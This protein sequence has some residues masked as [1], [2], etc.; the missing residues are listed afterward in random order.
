MSYKIVYKNDGTVIG[1]GFPDEDSA[2]RELIRRGVKPGQTANFSVIP[3]KERT[4]YEERK[5]RFVNAPNKSFVR[6]NPG[7]DGH[8]AFGHRVDVDGV[9]L[10]ESVPAVF[11]YCF[12]VTDSDDLADVAFISFAVGNETVELFSGHWKSPLGPNWTSGKSLSELKIVF[13]H[14]FEVVFSF[15]F[16]KTLTVS[17]E[18]NILLIC[19]VCS[20]SAFRLL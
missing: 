9:L 6:R 15:N 4:S 17:I 14:Y 2:Y 13:K 1:R 11:I 3:D 12:P 5:N 8:N 10:A 16:R 18:F 19:P 20:H 7:K